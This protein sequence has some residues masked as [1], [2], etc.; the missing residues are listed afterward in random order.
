M[1]LLN[2][3][4]HNITVIVGEETLEIPASGLVVRIATEEREVGKLLYDGKPLPI[5]KQELKNLVI[6]KDGKE[7]NKKEIKKEFENVY[8]VIVSMPIASYTK[9]L[10]RLIGKPELKIYT[11]N[12][13]KAIRDESGR[14][15]GV[16]SLVEWD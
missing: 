13:S 1:K 16:P 5:V 14:I 4:P 3:T 11:P 12:T 9:E 2:L 7:L 8:G 10:R 15:I 6:L